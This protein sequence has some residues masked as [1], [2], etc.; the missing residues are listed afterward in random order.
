MAVSSVLGTGI[1]L[2]NHFNPDSLDEEA[3]RG[4]VRIFSEMG[5]T[6]CP[7]FATN[8]QN[9]EL[10]TN[11]DTLLAILLKC[12]DLDAEVAVLTLTFWFRFV[13]D[14]LNYNYN[15]VDVYMSQLNDLIGK[16]VS[17]LKYP[18]DI[19]NVQEF[20]EENDNFEGNRFAILDLLED[21][22]R[23]VGSDYISKQ[24]HA[25]LT[26]DIVTLEAVLFAFHGVEK[27]ISPE[28]IE[29]ANLFH[30]VSKLVVQV[31]QKE[32]VV[33]TAN[34]FVGSYAN[35]LVRS[36]D[37]NINNNIIN[38]LCKYA[39]N[40][41]TQTTSCKCLNKF[42]GQVPVDLKAITQLYSSTNWDPKNAVVLVECIAKLISQCQ[43]MT[44]VNEVLNY[45]LTVENAGIF[46]IYCEKLTALVQF[47][48]ANL[49]VEVIRHSWD[50]LAAAAERDTSNDTNLAEKVC[51]FYKHAVRATKALFEPFL[52][53]LMKLLTSL[54]ANKLK[55]PYLYAASI[56]ISEFPTV[57]NLSEMVHAL[58]NVFFAKFTNLEQF[59]H[60]PD[61]VEEYFYLV[62]RALS[63][64]PNIIIGETKLFECTLNASVT[65][66]QVMHKDAYK[67]IL[68]FQESTLDC[69]ALPTSPAAQEL[70]RRH[71]GNVIEVICNNL[72]NGTVLN[73]DGGSGSVCGVL[74]KLN[75]LFPSVFV[76]KLNS[77]NANVLVQGCARG[78]R[79]DLY[80]AVRRFVDQH[81][82]AKR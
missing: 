26:P 68:V 38:Y 20:L 4:H 36:N 56:L 40:P 28:S 27:F 19:G 49:V 51:R 70:L 61:I 6:L 78:D 37:A 82:G 15:F 16:C 44:L 14:V 17:L 79:K 21:I 18:D 13:D 52:N 60:C 9:A 48:P 69:K 42:A 76:E 35:W 50:N 23:L 62:G 10:R 74:Y 81:G 63:Y 8:I 46:T 65:G 30:L 3:V 54:F 71:C 45:L 73:L 5:E 58:S 67:A 25:R 33:N 75:R 53:N 22:C 39:Q 55:S 64:A 1:Q 43:D 57:P 41:G 31:D 80:H 34:L 47:L 7:F 11:L 29:V 12:M 72:R 66:L 2:A 77:L 32:F 24:I 59:T